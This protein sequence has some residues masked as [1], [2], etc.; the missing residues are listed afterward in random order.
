MFLAVINGRIMERS[1][2]I[3]TLIPLEEKGYEV[4]E[5]KGPVPLW[6]PE[7]DVERPLD[8]RDASQRDK[9]IKDRYKRQR[10]RA[11]PSTNECLAMIYRDMKN[12]TT[13]YVDAVDAIH[14]QFPKPA[15]AQGGSH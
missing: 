10:R 3:D 14:T 13:E 4:F 12:G 2:D 11:M 8:P 6:N 9:D 7:E 5:W 1:D 15:Q